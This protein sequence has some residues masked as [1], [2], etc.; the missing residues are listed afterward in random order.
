MRDPQ[1]SLVWHQKQVLR[2]L[3]E[4]LPADH[5][6]R[7]E[8]AKLWAAEGLLIPFDWQ[9][10]QTLCS[11]RISFVTSP[12]E[13]C[14]AQLFDAA[15]L[16]LELLERANAAAADLKDASAWNVVYSGC[17]P[18]FVDLTSLE[19]LQTHAW[20]AAG[21][22]VR[23][24]V[25][26]LWLAQG[27][28]LNACNT[29]RMA[30]DG[31]S[32]EWVRKTLGW[33]R[34]FSRCWPLVADSRSTAEMRL[35]G[36]V[37]ANTPAYRKRLIASLRW[38]LDGLQPRLNRSSTWSNY[39]SDRGHYSSVAITEKREHVIRW[40]QLIRPEWTL[41]LGCNTGEFSQAAL[42]AGSKV[43]A[44]DADHEAVQAMYMQ[45]KLEEK[46]FP[47][48]VPLDDIHSGRGWGGQEHAGLAS[49][50]ESSA[51]VVMMLALLHHL[52]IASAVG[53]EHVARFAAECT[54]HWL[55]VEW[56]APSDPQ[57]IH[58]CAQRRRCTEEF[59]VNLQRQVFVDAGFLVKQEHSLAGGHRFLAL[60]EKQK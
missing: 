46:L 48:L 55:I 56:L 32:P 34:F 45:H 59:S 57:V 52:S 8:Q 35:A 36:P 9:D 44:L 29:F 60:L 40:L 6:L 30:R 16:T 43:I 13:W 4:K 41:D 18:V 38:M 23:H 20:W 17:K 54:R 26:P 33:R 1:A 19:P 53:L 42:D 2:N 21:Q 11:P 50:L 25:S 39:T 31:A 14:D 24:F 58:L 7:T 10:S 27:T 51:D 28:G 3:R 37:L 15:C 49:R 47:V 22:F 5:P 12:E